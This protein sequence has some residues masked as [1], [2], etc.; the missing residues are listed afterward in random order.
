MDMKQLLSNHNQQQHKVLIVDDDIGHRALLEE[1]V[2][3]MGYEAD[4]AEDGFEAL[5]KAKTGTFDA[6]L[7][8]VRMPG[9]D[10]F[11]IAQEIRNNPSTEKTPAII[12]VTALDSQEDKKRSS[13]VGASAFVNKPVNYKQLHSTLKNALEK[14]REKQVKTI[15][16]DNNCQLNVE[17]YIKELTNASREAYTAHIETLERLAIAAEYRDEDTG[18]HVRRVGE[19][20]ALI[21]RQL[22]FSPGE[23]EVLRYASQLH[24]IGKIGIPDSVLLKP[25]ILTEEE[26]EIIKEHPT[27]GAR[28]LGDSS[29][30]YLQAGEEI[31][32]THQ[33]RW[34]GSG[35]PKGLK[36]N[37]IPVFGRITAV[38]DVFD[39]LSSTRPYRKAL[40]REKCLEIMKKGRG[41]LFDP[42]LLDIFFENKELIF[43][44]Q[45]KTQEN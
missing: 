9:K 22:H 21:A 35:Y 20:A 45:E 10:G 16:Q 17:P 42:Y 3:D 4:T 18:V 39:A 14:V 36:G 31:A 5:A 30:K 25:G 33:E 19:Y 32:L 37:D 12:M 2:K 13:K 29:S 38:A 23:I 24:D 26:W 41:S 44:I 6:L 40:P 43:E 11:E 27:I 28:I 15:K 34:D 8:D 1:M 7:L